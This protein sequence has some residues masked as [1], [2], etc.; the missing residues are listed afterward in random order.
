MAKIK[1]KPCP[2]CGAK[3]E[4]KF[5]DVCNYDKGKW[6]VNHYC[7]TGA[8]AR[9]EVVISAYGSTKKEAVERWNRRM[10]NGR[11]TARKSTKA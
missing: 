7:E 9:L 8:L 6:E 11:N 3:V 1:L 10:G 5:P 4:D 2:F